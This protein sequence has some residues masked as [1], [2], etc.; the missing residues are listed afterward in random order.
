M[1][2][3]WG[4]RWSIEGDLRFGSQRDMMRIMDRT[5]T[6]AALPIRYSQGFNPHPRFSL[7]CPRPVAVASRDELLVL[8]LDRPVDPGQTL[9]K[10]NA[11]CPAGLIFFRAEQLSGSRI[12]RPLRIHY[13]LPVESSKTAR[14][15][16]RLEGLA[17]RESWP[18][19]RRRTV[20]G[21]RSLSSR[22]I[23]LKALTERISLDENILH[24]VLIRGGDCW[25]R[26]GELLELTG[27]DPRTDLS[28]TFRTKVEYE[29]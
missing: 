26:P 25:A 22:I 8:I 28:R 16:A 11:H 12:P 7:P 19:E 5:V 2:Q 1:P 9:E 18:I 14:V 6:R 20:R 13:E 15:L 29:M 17:R 10:L 23:D 3:Y 24:I 4:I 27:L 21:S